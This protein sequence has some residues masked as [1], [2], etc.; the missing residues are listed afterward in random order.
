MAKLR[1]FSSWRRCRATNSLV[2]LFGIA[3]LFWINLRVH[4]SA[5]HVLHVDVKIDSLTMKHIPKNVPSLRQSSQSTTKR[6]QSSNLAIFYNVFI[7]PQNV[8]NGV[9]IIKS[10]TQQIANIPD[11][12]DTP[13]YFNIIG[14]NYTERF[15]PASLHC[16][17][18]SYYPEGG[19]DITLNDLYQYCRQNP[20]SQVMYLHNKG[21]FSPCRNNEMLRHLVTSSLIRVKPLPQHPTACNVQAHQWE[22]LPHFHAQ[23]NMWLAKCSYVAQLM[24]PKDLDRRRIEMFRQILL[25]GEVQMNKNEAHIDYRCLAS[26][27][28]RS[29]PDISMQRQGMLR[30]VGI[31]RYG[32]ELWVYSHPNVQPCDRDYS[33]GLPLLK[34]PQSRIKRSKHAWFRQPGRLFECQYL[35]G[36]NPPNAS[37]F[38]KYYENSTDPSEPRSCRPQEL[39]SSK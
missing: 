13:I 16:E 32:H 17:F 4:Q 1:R 20:K 11:H 6:Y 30:A 34:R 24:P 10:Q 19:E 8:S 12:R 7:N 3:G 14:F 25:P 36:Q 28:N 18:L 22:P 31:G 37:F 26:V 27:F 9:R 29:I 35:Y 33:L 23:A 15:C 39:K 21:S 2:L 5:H 38:W